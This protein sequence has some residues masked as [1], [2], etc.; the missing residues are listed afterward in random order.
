MNVRTLVAALAVSLVF[1]PAE[2]AAKWTAPNTKSPSGKKRPDTNATSP[3]IDA[4]LGCTAEMKANPKPGNA[5]ESAYQ[6]YVYR[7]DNALAADPKVKEFDASLHQVHDLVPSKLVPA[8]DKYFADYASGVGAAELPLSADC[9]SAAEAFLKLTPKKIEDSKIAPN[10]KAI[11]TKTERD[12]FRRDAGSAINTAR[13]AHENA[14]HALFLVYPGAYGAK[15]ATND[16]FKKAFLPTKQRFDANEAALVARETE[17]G[18]RPV[19]NAKDGTF[20]WVRIANGATVT[21]ASDI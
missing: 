19:V 13:F 15:C 10:P 12:Q 3:M 14:R 9:P 7:R 11:Y 2:A 8:C 16:R 5:S 4:L 21:N 17:L 18:V 20:T 6:D 1:V